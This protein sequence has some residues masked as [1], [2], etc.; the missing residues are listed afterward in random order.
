MLTH[1]SPSHNTLPTNTSLQYIR[2]AT[3]SVDS[4]HYFTEEAEVGVAITSDVFKDHPAADTTFFKSVK[5]ESEL[6]LYDKEAIEDDESEDLEVKSSYSVH[7]RHFFL[8][9]IQFPA[10]TELK[11]NAT[12]AKFWDKERYEGFIHNFDPLI[13]TLQLGAGNG[14][15]DGEY[16][17]C[18]FHAVLPGQS[19]G[20]DCGIRIDYD[21]AEWGSQFKANFWYC[22]CFYISGYYEGL[23]PDDYQEGAFPNDNVWECAEDDCN[24][25]FPFG[26]QVEAK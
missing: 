2:G 26:F 7:P 16:I 1:I 15:V 17:G 22:D 5:T 6:A 4:A 18:W 19:D 20:C 24:W 10:Y 21:K 13:S 12:A 8:L 25:A 3:D 23:P 11:M 9:E 14:M